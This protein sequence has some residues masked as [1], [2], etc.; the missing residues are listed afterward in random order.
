MF[1]LKNAFDKRKEVAA[2][3]KNEDKLSPSIDIKEE[4]SDGLFLTPKQES[5]FV[6]SQTEFI[7]QILSV[8]VFTTP[9]NLLTSLIFV[10]LTKS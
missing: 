7:I 8:S 2:K 10:L 3:I 1:L 9:E 5:I 6:K 4:D